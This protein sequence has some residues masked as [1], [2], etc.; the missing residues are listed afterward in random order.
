MSGKGLLKIS[1]VFILIWGILNVVAG[2]L[3]MAGFS[4]ADMLATEVR[5]ELMALSLGT[6]IVIGI[7][8]IVAAS[9]GFSAAKE[10]RKAN[11]CILLGG[12]VFALTIVPV[13]LS[14]MSNINW[15]SFIASLLI[16]ALYLIGAFLRKANPNR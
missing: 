7:F 8:E 3:T 14:D 12:F 11:R 16:P 2:I 10:G 6:F 13:F 5:E 9:F 4:F 15:P 1:S